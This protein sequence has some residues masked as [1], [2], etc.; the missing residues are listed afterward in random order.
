MVLHL[1]KPIIVYNSNVPFLFSSANQFTYGVT[2]FPFIFI[3]NFND[4]RYK[5]DELDI[6][7][8]IEDIVNHE[9]IHFQQILETGIIGFYS[10]FFIELLIK[11]I[12]WKSWNKSYS[13]IS[14]EREAYKHMYDKHYLE[15][16]KRYNWFKYL[17]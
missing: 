16:R 12:F 11:R 2:I 13:N 6:I 5:P 14:F 9:K 8:N 7:Y 3:V 4:S 1:V 15:K 17:Y 10:L